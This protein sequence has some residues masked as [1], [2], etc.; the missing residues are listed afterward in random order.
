MYDLV[1]NAPNIRSGGGYILLKS[2]VLSFKDTQ[3]KCLLIVNEKLKQNFS[4][5]ESIDVVYVRHSI[6]ARF[7]NEL[8]LRKISNRANKI[9][10]FGNLPPIF[11]LN[12]HVLVY[13][14]NL[15]IISNI[16]VT[17]FLLKQK[18]RI[19]IERIWFRLC[20]NKADEF[21]VQTLSMKNILKNLTTSQINVFP[22]IAKTCAKQNIMKNID[23]IFPS[24]G[25]PHKNHKCLIESWI[26]LALK[27]VK[28]SLH[29]TLDEDNFPE[30]LLWIQDKVKKYN[31]N[32]VNL[33][34]VNSYNEMIH[35]IQSSGAVIFPSKFES[36]GLPL[37]EANYYNIPILAPELDYVRDIVR[38]AFTF[39][40][41]SP[42]SIC[43]AVLRH[44]GL[45][46]TQHIYS[47][48]EF[49]SELMID[50]V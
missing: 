46:H 13:I 23:Y 43:D 32:I 11:N 44:K 21:Y 38:P 37:V 18:I 9:L 2:V 25:E 30:L 16:S 10:M 17:G 41:E 24:S 12:T 6:Y 7:R 40:P 48:D 42:F 3:F 33:G 28:P 35:Y 29:I 1:I 14:Q 47:A 22:F 5:S 36:L 31:L 27:D 49:I 45:F 15:Y 34:N 19:L 39:N 50:V 4:E 20:I 8:F 26:L